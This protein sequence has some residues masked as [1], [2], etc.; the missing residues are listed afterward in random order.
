MS[1]Y[2]V[3][4]MV[5]E[6]TYEEWDCCNSLVKFRIFARNYVI[7]QMDFAKDV[8]S[9]AI[10]YYQKYFNNNYS[11]PKLDVIVIP[12]LDSGFTISWGVIAFRYVNI[13][14]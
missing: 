12:Y 14:Q 8:V 3:S 5:L 6:M 13:T 1:T 2:L 4:Y 11:L 7:C 9:K 10:E